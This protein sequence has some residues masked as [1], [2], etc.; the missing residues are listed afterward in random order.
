MDNLSFLPSRVTENKRVQARC[1]AFTLE[2][3]GT[4]TVT[5]NDYITLAAGE[6]RA[7]GHIP[8]YKYDIDLNISFATGGTNNLLIIEFQ[9]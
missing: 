8:G 1:L 6:S 5:V 7:F 4:S 9:G 2:N 3:S